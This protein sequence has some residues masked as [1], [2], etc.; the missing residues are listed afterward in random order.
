MKNKD[1]L[2]YL[3]PPNFSASLPKNYRWLDLREEIKKGDLA[4]NFDNTISELP[5]K[6]AGLKVGTYN[7]FIRKIKTKLRMG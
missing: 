5:H 6:Y 2:Y 7:V 4:I 3:K 1:S